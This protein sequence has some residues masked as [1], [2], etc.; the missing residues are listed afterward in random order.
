[1]KMIR[2]QRSDQHTVLPRTVSAKL[3]P[4]PTQATDRKG[5]SQFRPPGWEL[6][7]PFTIR[8]VAARSE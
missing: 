8:I 7:L 2:E 6:D 5:F 3:R 1:M 4:P